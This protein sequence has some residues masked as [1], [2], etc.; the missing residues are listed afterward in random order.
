MYRKHEIS[1]EAYKKGQD[2]YKSE[3]AKYRSALD[4]AGSANE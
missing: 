4:G 1:E 2:E 3:M